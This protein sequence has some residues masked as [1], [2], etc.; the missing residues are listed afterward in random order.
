MSKPLRVLM[1]EDSAHDATLLARELRNAGFDLTFERVETQEAM[2]EALERGGWDIILADHPMPGFNAIA[3]L[4]LIQ[5][6]KLDIPLIM[7]SGV[8]PQEEAFEV[9]RAGARDFV[10]K[11]KLGRLAG[12]VE[13]EVSEAKDRKAG[14]QATVTRDIT[15]RKRSEQALQASE[16]RLRALVHSLD[17]IIFELDADGTYRNVWTHDERLLARPASELIGRRASDVLGKEYFQPFL[18]VIQRVLESG[19][20]KDLEYSMD[21]RGEKHWFQARISPIHA[22]QG[23]VKTACLVIREITERKHADEALRESEDRYRDLVENSGVLIGTHDAAGKVLSINRAMLSLLGVS[24]PEKVIGRPFSE[25]IPPEYRPQFEVY[26]ETVLSKGHAEGLT[27]ILLPGGGKR[28]IEYRNTLRTENFSSPIVRCVAVDVTERKRAEEEMRRA[29]EAAESANRA[30][31]EFL[32]NMSHEI[33]TPMNGIIGM[34]ELALETELTAEQRDYLGTVKES[35]DAL[36]TII[37]DILDFSKIDAGKMSLDP[38]DFNLRDSLGETARLLAPAAHQ[39]GLELVMAIDPDVPE[40][41]RGDPARLR[42]IIVNLVGN[43][44]KFTSQGE[45]V[46]RIEME[47]RREDGLL[48]HFIVQDTGIGIPKEKQ[49]VIFEAFAQADSSTTRRFGGTGLGLT[50]SARLVEMMQGRIWVESEMGI[51]SKFHF[52]AH[53]GKAEPPAAALRSPAPAST[54]LAGIRILLVDDNATNRRYLGEVLRGWGL[55]VD[56]AAGAEDALK[57]IHQ[58]QSAAQHFRIV[59]TDAQMPGVDGFML[60]ER[61]KQEAYLDA[62]VVMMISSSGQ[63]GD[64]ARCRELGI[65]AY[66]T[67]PVRESELLDAILRVLEING[68]APSGPNLV[69]RHSLRETRRSLQILLVEDNPVNTLLAA[70]LLE[71]RGH[72]VC[73]VTNGSEALATIEKRRFDLAIL[74]VQMAGMD[75]LEL[76]Q[77]IRATE[78]STGN[79]LPLIAMTAH[80]MKGDR[81]RC[82]AAGMDEYLAK[83]INAREMF[84]TIDSVFADHPSTKSPQLDESENPQTRLTRN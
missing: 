37:N 59:L 73:C 22:A 57:A 36:L 5:S 33:R 62:P 60:A 72:V 39:K 44:T 51:G 81:E 30:K 46:L 24:N 1:V 58:A 31:S 49:Q 48:L 75:G 69:T 66:L 43:A 34:T 32:A 41:V 6:K 16:E 63:R 25:L 79:H 20:R 71:K 18:D 65:G 53:F 12:A 2:D 84:E 8:L 29:K 28:V 15:E 67:K 50:I 23:S 83:P 68:P 7:V 26:L 21:V 9:M 74:D 27:T 78:T 13:R 70:R 64:A 11:N 38:I 52:T 47:S 3:A 10:S 45:I 76:A 61:I 55:T 14:R 17:D 56:L 40:F 19:K 4:N 80:A 42:Q 54:S 77:T 82:L 35:A